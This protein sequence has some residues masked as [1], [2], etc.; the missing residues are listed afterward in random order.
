[1]NIHK[2]L[3]QLAIE[4]SVNLNEVDINIQPNTSKLFQCI[5]NGTTKL[6]K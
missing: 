1:M 2:C 6:F 4:Q 3:R 5:V